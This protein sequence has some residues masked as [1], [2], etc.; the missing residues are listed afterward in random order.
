MEIL[1]TLQIAE[2]SIKQCIEEF[3][4][5]FKEELSVS[6]LEE[7]KLKYEK[8]YKTHNEDYLKNFKMYTIIDIVLIILEALSMD[9]VKQL[10]LSE[11]EIKI[12][13]QELYERWV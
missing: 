7:L 12:A 5:R 1:P 6:E 10:S 8:L 2:K 4:K 13:A 11:E 3:N 9:R